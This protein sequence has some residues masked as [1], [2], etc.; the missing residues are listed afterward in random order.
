MRTNVC[1]PSIPATESL[2]SVNKASPIDK[3]TYIQI[4]KLNKKLQVIKTIVVVYQFYK[5]NQF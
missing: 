3:F 4:R 1:K 5:F 2:F